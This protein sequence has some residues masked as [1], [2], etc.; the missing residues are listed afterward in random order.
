MLVLVSTLEDGTYIEVP[1]FAI[2][3][4]ELTVFAGFNAAQVK[5]PGEEILATMVIVLV[6]GIT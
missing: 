6:E 4:T 3:K 2:V 5:R 1:K